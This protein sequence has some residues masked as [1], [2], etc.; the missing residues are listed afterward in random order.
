[1]GFFNK[2]DSEKRGYSGLEEKDLVEFI[3]SLS[4]QYKLLSPANAI[5]NS[6]VWTAVNIL[7]SDISATPLQLVVN[8]KVDSSHAI[9]NLLNIKPNSLMNA[10]DFW[11]M[12]IANLL[13]TGESYA[14]IVRDKSGSVIS[15]D[16]IPLT[17]MT[18]HVDYSLYDIK[19]QFTDK[20]NRTFELEKN[21]VLH[22]KC[23][24]MDGLTGV[25]PLTALTHEINIAQD[26]KHTLKDFIKNGNKINGIL[27]VEGA[28]LNK[29]AKNR[30]REQF[31]ESYRTESAATTIILDKNH[32]YTPINVDTS[33]LKYINDTGAATTNKIAQVFGIPLNRFGMELSNS[34]DAD[35]QLGY[36]QN[37]LSKYFNAIISELN[38]KLL[39]P[40]EQLTS[41]F[42]Y[43][44]SDFIKTTPDKQVSYLKE[45]VASG[46]MTIN[47]ARKEIKLE[48]VEKGDDVL[49]S[50][51]FTQLSNLA[52]Y[53]LANQ[54][55]A[56]SIVESP[57]EE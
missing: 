34:S 52:D 44:T 14:R 5:K 29:E 36:L 55:Q 50:L 17:K 19:Y 45:A 40:A 22:F 1:M 49:I 51:N 8:N 28:E 54:K 53:Q 39:T 57:P 10:R 11:F 4:P 43:N 56:E 24:T 41:E 33:I 27:K 18:V 31:E 46:L 9:N 23:F 16:T 26:G 48:K 7:S 3:S 30:L 32:S 15:I 6:D 37:T 2:R 21:E 47:E 20:D 12:I 25:S 13:L 42:S 38:A 35:A